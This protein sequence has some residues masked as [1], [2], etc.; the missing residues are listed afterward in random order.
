M[1]FKRWMMES[2]G[3][4]VISLNRYLKDKPLDL[5]NFYHEFAT[6][7]KGKEKLRQLGLN[8]AK[9]E[10]MMDDDP[11]RFYEVLQ[12]LE[13]GLTEKEREEFIWVLQQMSPSDA[14]SWGSMDYNRLVSP[15]EWL[16][17]FSDHA[18]EISREGFTKGAFDASKLSLTTWLGDWA[19]RGGGYNFAFV[20]LSRYAKQAAMTRKYGQDAVVFK[21]GGVQAYHYGD[22][23]DQVVFWGRT[24]EPSSTI[25]LRRTGS[26]EWCIVPRRLERECVKSGTFDEVAEWIV[27]NYQQYRRIL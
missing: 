25:Y 10:K 24:V 14:P 13:D 12:K 20:L 27:T 9:L 3:P 7:A 19:K 6:W 1:N 17:H 8:L 21:A 26:N 15:D 2:W 5:P 18:W 23:E 16:V 11:D 4:E 22:E